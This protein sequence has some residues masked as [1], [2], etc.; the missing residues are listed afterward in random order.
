MIS[1]DIRTG[2]IVALITTID[3]SSTV[4]VASSSIQSSEIS[5]Q[6]LEG[7]LSRMVS[8]GGDSHIK[9]TGVLVG[10]FESDP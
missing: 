5:I 8:P 1:E 10:F 2:Q 4:I 9:V 3:V 7:A 6:G